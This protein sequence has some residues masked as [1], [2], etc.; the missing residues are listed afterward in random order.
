MRFQKGKSGN[1]R[2]RPKGAKNKSTEMI[3]RAYANLLEG[4]LNNMTEWIKKVA[5]KNPKEAFYMLVALNEF[6]VPKL[7]RKELVGDEDYPIQIEGINYLLPNNGNNDKADSKAASSV[8]GS[9]E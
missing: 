2:G 4:N 7:A 5:K 9:K 1:P 6:V 3:K 8:R